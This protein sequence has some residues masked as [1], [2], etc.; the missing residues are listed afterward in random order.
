VVLLDG[1]PACPIHPHPEAG[2]WGCVKSFP[3]TRTRLVASH[4]SGNL[5][6][7]DL[8]RVPRRFEAGE[9]REYPAVLRHVVKSDSV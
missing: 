9:V 4:S 5:L 8:Y 7:N 6:R 2:W 3:R 1:S